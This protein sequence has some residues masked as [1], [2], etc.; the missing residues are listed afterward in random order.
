M[1]HHIVRTFISPS[2]AVASRTA[3]TSGRAFGPIAGQVGAWMRSGV[4]T[5]KPWM[6]Q[7]ELRSHG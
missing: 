2:F 4:A 3:G 7:W 1:S 5:K 6:P